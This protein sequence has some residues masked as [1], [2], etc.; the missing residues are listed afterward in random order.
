MTELTLEEGLKHIQDLD[1]AAME[2]AKKTLGQRSKAIKQSGTLRRS[3]YK[4]CRNSK[5]FP[6]KSGEKS[7]GN[8]L[9]R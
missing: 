3:H 1:K 7:G 2:Q 5:G 4:N 6:C 8:L 9:R